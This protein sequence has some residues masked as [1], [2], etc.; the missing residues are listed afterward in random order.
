MLFSNL[1]NQHNLLPH[2]GELYYYPQFFSP[3]VSNELFN[4]LINTIAWKQEPIVLFGKQ[5]MQPRLTALYGDAAISYGYSGITMQPIEWT[6]A[7][8]TIKQAI[9]PITKTLFTTVLLNYYRNG[10]DSMGWHRDNEPVLGKN[11]LIAS[12]SFGAARKFSF[13][14]YETKKT[15]ISLLLEH[16]S[17]LIMKGATNHFWEHQ[18]PKT[19]QNNN[20]RVNLTFRTIVNHR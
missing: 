5:I 13:R 20:P 15:T 8:Q 1:A 14:D 3:S 12:V 2:N 17:L 16:G 11:P 19:K 4:T 18:L 6:A 7:L 9:E 10:N